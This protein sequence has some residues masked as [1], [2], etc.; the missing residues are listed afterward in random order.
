MVSVVLQWIKDILRKFK[1]W[2][3]LVITNLS[4]LVKTWLLSSG[5]ILFEIIIN[6]IY[7]NHEIYKLINYRGNNKWGE[8]YL[9]VNL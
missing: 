4:L 2:L 3:G 9:V 1:I 5:I 7:I 6:I 8:Y